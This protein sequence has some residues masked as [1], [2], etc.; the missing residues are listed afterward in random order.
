MELFFQIPTWERKTYLVPFNPNEIRVSRLN[1]RFYCTIY[2]LFQELFHR[3]LPQIVLENIDRAIDFY[4]QNRVRYGIYCQQL[5]LKY[6]TWEK[7][8]Q[9]AIFH[10]D[11]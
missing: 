3:Y 5:E 1:F 2:Y 8:I 10:I 4:E 9:Y 7:L 11:N 6:S